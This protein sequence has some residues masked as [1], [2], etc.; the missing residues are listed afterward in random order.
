[1]NA[2]LEATGRFSQMDLGTDEDE[3]SIEMHLPYIRKVFEKKAIKIVPILVGRLSEASQDLYGKLLAP[4]LA[5][6][7][8]FFV[9]S[10]DFCHWGQRF[11]YTYYRPSAD[12]DP[13]FLKSSFKAQAGNAAIWESIRD[14][15]AEGIDA[16]S[17]GPTSKRSARQAVRDFRRY[18]DTTRNTVC[19]AMPIAV[20]LST[21]AALEG[22]EGA[23]LTE[24][25]FT[26]YEQSSQCITIRDSSVSYASAFVRFTQ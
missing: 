20:L 16:I 19:G 23:K 21:L 15:D 8:K 7:K 18:L 25:R 14:L 13:Q 11:Q 4:Y 2:E 9:I 10:S 22:Q 17:H 5:N 12:A 6:P 26:R 1:M 24:C 3:H